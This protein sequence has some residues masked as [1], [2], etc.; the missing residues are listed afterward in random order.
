MSTQVLIACTTNSLR[1]SMASGSIF[2]NPFLTINKMYVTISQFIFSL[3]FSVRL[4][5]E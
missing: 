2:L 5:M 1:V 3:T 4:M